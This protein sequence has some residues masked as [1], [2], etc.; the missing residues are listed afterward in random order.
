MSH[1]PLKKKKMPPAELGR[2]DLQDAPGVGSAGE[3]R[4]VPEPAEAREGGRPPASL[5]GTCPAPRPARALS[6]WVGLWE[7]QMDRWWDR[8]PDTHTGQMFVN[9]EAETHVAGCGERAWNP[10]RHQGLGGSGQ[11]A[12]VPAGVEGRMVS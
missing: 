6:M 12:D 7:L 3:Q 8:R 2:T 4:L 9:P 1:A 11:G 10:H 5:E